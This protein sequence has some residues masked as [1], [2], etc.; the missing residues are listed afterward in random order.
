MTSVHAAVL[1]SLAANPRLLKVQ[2]NQKPENGYDWDSLADKHVAWPAFAAYVTAETWDLHASKCACG[3]RALLGASSGLCW[4]T[5]DPGSTTWLLLPVRRDVAPRCV[6]GG[7]RAPGAWRASSPLRLLRLS[8]DAVAS[9]SKAACSREDAFADTT[10][11]SVVLRTVAES[12]ADDGCGGAGLTGALASLTYFTTNA[13]SSAV[14]Y[15]SLGCDSGCVDDPGSD[16]DEDSWEYDDIA[17]PTWAAR[18]AAT[19]KAD[20]WCNALACAPC[21]AG[22]THPAEKRLLSFADACSRCPPKRDAPLGA[23]HARSDACFVE[24]VC[25]VAPPG[26]PFWGKRRD[27]ASIADGP[28]AQ[29][30]LPHDLH[31][32]GLCAAWARHE[33]GLRRAPF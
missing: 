33:L 4:F 24:K 31:A 2:A 28:V 14:D 10:V 19:R 9:S 17:P 23:A 30:P 32:G 21:P 13:T 29:L 22:G 27:E 25:T 15:D 20:F 26:V 1:E 5:G 7:R 18:D 16:G 3:I 11:A 8:P 12:F 6:C